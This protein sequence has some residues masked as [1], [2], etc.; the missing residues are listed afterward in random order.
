MATAFDPVCGKEIDV[1]QADW[2]ILYTDYH[3]PRAEGDQPAAETRQRVRYYFCSS[4]CK[5]KF[6]TSPGFYSSVGQKP[7]WY[8]QPGAERQ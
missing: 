3:V 5:T 6:D 8:S 2:L 1:A 4:D 7:P